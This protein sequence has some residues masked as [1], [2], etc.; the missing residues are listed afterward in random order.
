MR[1]GVP[2][3][4]NSPRDWFLPLRLPLLHEIPYRLG[5]GGVLKRESSLQ[6]ATRNDSTTLENQLSLGAHQYRAS[7]QHPPRRRQAYPHASRTP[8]FPHELRV[9][10][11]RRRCHVD[12]AGDVVVF[13]QPPDRAD[14]VDLVNPRHELVT[15]SSLPP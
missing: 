1:A 12:G 14:E 15:A 13:D 5:P 9:R 11:R 3:R 4:T 2:I 6:K 10:Q 7:F 8:D